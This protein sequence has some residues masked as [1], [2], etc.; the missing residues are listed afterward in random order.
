LQ[1]NINKIADHGDTNNGNDPEHSLSAIQ[2]GGFDDMQ[3]RYY[4]KN[5][6]KNNS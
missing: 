4:I 3:K 6:S 1:Q 2:G 5:K